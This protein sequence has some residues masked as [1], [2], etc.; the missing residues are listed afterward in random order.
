MS[1]SRFHKDQAVLDRRGDRTFQG[2][3]DAVSFTGDGS[4]MTFTQVIVHDRSDTPADPPAGTFLMWMDSATGDV[5]MKITDTG[6]TTKTALIADF[7][8]L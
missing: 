5:S 3:V 6:G 4:L 1:D 7:S 2:N 8:A